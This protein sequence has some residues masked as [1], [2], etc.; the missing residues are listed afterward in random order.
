MYMRGKLKTLRERERESREMCT[1]IWINIFEPYITGG[2]TRTSIAHLKLKKIR[3][4]SK[5][6]LSI[7]Y[8]NSSINSDWCVLARYFFSID[9]CRRRKK[10]REMDEEKEE[11]GVGIFF[12]VGLK[13]DTHTQPLL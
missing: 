7:G 5:C 6:S 4:F 9:D 12:V 2:L 3:L 10:E 13:T 11:R 8:N 1:C